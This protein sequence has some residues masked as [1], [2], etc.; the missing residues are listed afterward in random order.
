M[1]TQKDKATCKA[2][3]RIRFKSA[4]PDDICATVHVGKVHEVEGV[5]ILVGVRGYKEL[6]SILDSEILEVINQATK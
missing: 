2:G 3:D 4:R 5:C 6:W 1:D